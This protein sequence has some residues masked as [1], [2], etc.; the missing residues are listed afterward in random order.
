MRV[1][2]VCVLCCWSDSDDTLPSYVF[3]IERMHVESGASLRPLQRDYT[4]IKE[5]YFCFRQWLTAKV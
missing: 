2:R 5:G 4:D 1:L 3:S